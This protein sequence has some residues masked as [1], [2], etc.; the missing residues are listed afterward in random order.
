MSSLRLEVSEYN[1]SAT[2]RHGGVWNEAEIPITEWEDAMHRVVLPESLQ[3][4]LGFDEPVLR[5]SGGK[6]ERILREHAQLIEQR[7]LSDLSYY[8]ST[9]IFA[10][11]AKPTLE[12]WHVF[13]QEQGRWTL[14]VIGRGNN[15]SLNFVTLFSP[16]S[17]NKLPNRIARGEYIRRK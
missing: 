14:A 5:W 16:S 12:T 8:L 3:I 7:Q 10:G 9:W 17:P 13:F 11:R 2:R 15:V 4:A 6:R 1:R